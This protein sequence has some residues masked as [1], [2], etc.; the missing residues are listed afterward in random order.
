M[1]AVTYFQRYSQKENVVTNNT[2]LLLSRLYFY[3]P[4][5]LNA[6]LNDLLADLPEVEVGVSFIQQTGGAKGG[7][8]PD[9]MLSQNSFR[10]LVET[11]LAAEAFNREQ[12]ENHLK[13]FSRGGLNILLLLSKDR[14]REE[15]LFELNEAVET[16]GAEKEVVV[17]PAPVTFGELVA[18]FRAALSDRDYEMQEMADDFEDFCSEEGLLADEKYRLRVM[19]AGWSFEQ[20]VKYGVYFDESQRGFRTHSFLGLYKEK[21]VRAIGKVQ[22]A[23]CANLRD[24]ALQA[25]GGALSK[26]ETDRIK[27]IIMETAEQHGK[28]IATGHRFFLVDGFQETLFEKIS[29]FPIQRCKFFDLRELL[30]SNLPEALKDIATQLRTKTW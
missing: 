15:F 9:G 13:A 4:M 25:E 17:Y 23:V 5:R 26:D 2:L 14:P 18:S 24:D 8:V 3:N 22:K 28:D 29:K 16:Y 10:I 6:L 11:K 12:L 19:T 21:A 7:S 27:G 1:S 20:N 30:G